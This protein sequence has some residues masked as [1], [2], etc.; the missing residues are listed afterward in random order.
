MHCA[1]RGSLRKRIHYLTPKLISSFDIDSII[2]P[3]FPQ[4]FY[5]RNHELWRVSHGESFPNGPASETF[6]SMRSAH[7]KCVSSRSSKGEVNKSGLKLAAHG[8]GKRISRSVE[9]AGA[10]STFSEQR[11]NTPPPGQRE[12]KGHSLFC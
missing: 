9:E 8:C 7:R 3:S 11:E 10:A 5:Q 4:G 1:K 6:I 2:N 12:S